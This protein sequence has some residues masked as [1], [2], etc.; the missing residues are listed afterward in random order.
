MRIILQYH[1]LTTNTTVL[2]YQFEQ[3]YLDEDTKSNPHLELIEE[4]AKEAS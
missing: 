1:Y 3:Q 4:A 2:Q